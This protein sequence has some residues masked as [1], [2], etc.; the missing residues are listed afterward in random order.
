VPTIKRF[1]RRPDIT[2]KRLKTVQE[3]NKLMQEA[4]APTRLK[5]SA[6]YG[7]AMVSSDFN[8]ELA[9]FNL[10]AT[11]TKVQRRTTMV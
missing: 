2:A 4:A 10:D 7:C 5:G 8:H 1:A 3:I 9:P 11:V 6:L